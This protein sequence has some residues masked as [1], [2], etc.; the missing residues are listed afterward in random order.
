MKKQPYTVRGLDPPTSRCIDSR[1]RID[2]DA[3]ESCWSANVQANL[4]GVKRSTA[5]T[6]CSR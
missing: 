5:T 6:N 3:R 4:T 1:E 2:N